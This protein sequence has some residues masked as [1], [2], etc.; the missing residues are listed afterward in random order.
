MQR[1]RRMQWSGVA[2]VVLLFGVLLA[3]YATEQLTNRPVDPIWQLPLGAIMLLI[4]FHA[5]YFRQEHADSYNSG[6]ARHRWIGRTGDAY[7]APVVFFLPG[8]EFILIGCFMLV[9]G[10]YALV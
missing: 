1:T 2:L 8:A 5:I 4:G 10:L 3:M 6:V 9:R 7:I